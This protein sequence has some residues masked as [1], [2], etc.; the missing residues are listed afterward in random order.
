MARTQ[1]KDYPEI[2][3]NILRSA[4]KLFA[5][6][7]FSSTTIV[8][9]AQACQ[10]SRG[11]L[12]HYFTSKEEILTR[13]IT[14]H[15]EAMLVSLHDIGEERLEPEAHLRAIAR[16]IMEMNAFNNAEQIVLLNDWNQLDDGTRASVGAAQR[17][18]ISIVRDAMTRVDSAHRMTPKYA[19]TYAMSL[20]GSLNYTY[21][22]YDPNGPVTP[23]DYAD[24]VIDV[25]MSGFPAKA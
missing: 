3:Q 19:T 5:E 24:R 25:F 17:K 9:L 7:G 20:L 22:W 23:Q 16:K 1:S 14:E 21:A 8:D 13:I 4:A 11:A 15:V 6:K 10:S 2:R 18:I 12:Y